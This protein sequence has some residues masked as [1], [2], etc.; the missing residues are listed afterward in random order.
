MSVWLRQTLRWLW[1][2]D[3]RLAELMFGAMMLARA[4][5]LSLA[6]DEMTA[7]SYQ[8]FLDLLPPGIWALLFLTFGM[9]QF[10][11][12]LINGRWR[13]SPWLRMVGLLVSMVTYAV[14]TTGF[15]ESGAWLAVSV[16][17]TITAGAFWCLLNVSSKN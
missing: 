1:H 8:W 10:C 12:V 5:V 2:L 9:F 11:G 3:T 13:K 4:L 16:W 7:R 17:A 6:P 14:M 15:V